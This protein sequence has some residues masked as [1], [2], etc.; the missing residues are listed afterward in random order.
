MRFA[1]R[2][3]VRYGNPLFGGVAVCLITAYTKS[4]QQI[5]NPLSG[6][7]GTQEI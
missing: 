1:Q 6:R 5:R 2:D 3:F 7:G 4:D